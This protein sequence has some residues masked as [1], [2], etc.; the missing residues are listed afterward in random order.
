[1]TKDPKVFLRHILESIIQIEQYAGGK[2]KGEFLASPQI[3]DAV[4]RR[5]EIIGEASKN[6]P[7]E[8][9]DKYSAIPWNE[10]TGM[11]DVLIHEYFGVDTELVWRTVQKDLPI[12]KKHVE[13]II[14]LLP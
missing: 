1:M 2:S 8:L 10:I 3:Q 9:R 7:A 13:D 6:L 4:M 14:A 11:R 5:L 12:F